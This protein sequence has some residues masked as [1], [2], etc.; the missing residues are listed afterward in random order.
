MTIGDIYD[1]IYDDIYVQSSNAC[2]IMYKLRYQLHFKHAI[3][4]CFPKLKEK[5]E[6]AI[7]L[8]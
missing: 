5:F 4:L 7:H 8:L 3:C 6:R 2:A 1:D